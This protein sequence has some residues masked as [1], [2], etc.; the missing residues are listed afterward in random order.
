MSTPEVRKPSAPPLS[1]REMEESVEL[2]H[3]AHEDEGEQELLTLNMGP[4]HPA[5]HGVLRLLT[6]DLT[7]RQIG[8]QL[9]LSV[10]TVKTH[11]RGIYR[12]LGASS[13]SDAIACMHELGLLER[14]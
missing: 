5:T 6:T 7:Q 11:T 8:E 9:Y 2:S 12:K 14:V 10:N 4:H 1:Y 13:R 3:I